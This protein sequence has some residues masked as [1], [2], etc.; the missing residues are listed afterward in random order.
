[1]ARRL[2]ILSAKA[3]ML[4]GVAAGALFLA[5]GDIVHAQGQ[6]Q[7]GGGSESSGGG[8]GN[9]D[10]GSGGGGGNSDS[11]SGGGG[12]NSDS[13][14][15][16][17]GG[18][19]SSSGGSGGGSSGGSSSGGGSSNQ[20][21]S[22]GAAGSGGQS[23][24]SGQGGR[25]SDGPS[26]E[27]DDDSDRPA[28]A[29]GN[30][31]LNPHAGA[32]TG[33]PSSGTTKGDMYGDLVVLLRDLATGEPIV[34]GTSVDPETGEEITEYYVCLD[35]DCAT[36]VATVLGE[37]PE[38]VTAI[39]VDFGRS[40]VARAPDKVTDHALDE[41][42]SKLADADEVALDV[43]GRIVYSI[44]GTWY[45]IDSPLENLALYIDLATGLAADSTTATEAALD[46]LGL[47]T[48]DMAAS[49]LAGVADKTGDITLDYVV[50][51]NV[52]A[53]V[54]EAGVYYDYTD[55]AYTRDYPTEYTY[56]VS[57]DGALPVT[58]TLDI[59]AYLADPSV[60]GELP[61]STDYAALFAAAADDALEVIELVHTQIY[62]EILPGT[63]E[64]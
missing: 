33:N 17:S 29:G 20:G 19:S 16:G 48:L 49:L 6:G 25:P 8:G 32:G 28:W 15:G 34:A 7:G 26:D 40:S 35:A 46:A 39:E 5:S 61:E 43:S 12:G 64:D 63:I 27:A 59:N 42:L 54:V 21:G 37:I 31:E 30:P 22:D 4:A 36:T 1:M 55:F 23:G 57:I 62:T 18:G 60:N 51:E 10:S 47:A 58:A 53:G 24:A 44:D 56:W 2:I 14:S 3:A 11:G 50:N 9:S 52:I 13:G 41:A 38:G 45:T